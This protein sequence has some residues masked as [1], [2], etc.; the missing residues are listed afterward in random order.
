MEKILFEIAK[1]IQKNQER[2]AQAV[3][4]Y[5]EQLE[6]I[7]EAQAQ[8]EPTEENKELLDLLERLKEETIEKTSDELN[9]EQGLLV[10]YV[11]LTGIE[12]KGD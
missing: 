6:L 8:I 4:G 3:Q 2:E 9:H 5:T 11:E 10:E 12:I 1:I 7:K